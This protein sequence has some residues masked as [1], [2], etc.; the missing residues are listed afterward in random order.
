MVAAGHAADHD[1]Q[2]ADARQSVQR[3]E[4]VHLAA[5]GRAVDQ[6][7]R[8]DAGGVDRDTAIMNSLSLAGGWDGAD[9]SSGKAV[10]ASPGTRSRA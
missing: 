9:M 2:L 4:R 8:P 10:M 5:Q 1:G 6:G 7:Q 3:Q